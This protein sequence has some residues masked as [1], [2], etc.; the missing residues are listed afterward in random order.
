MGHEGGQLRTWGGRL[1]PF[2]AGGH[3]RFAR[4]AVVQGAAA[5]LFRTWTATVRAGLPALQGQVVI[6]L[7]D[8]LLLHV[9]QDRATAAAA[10]L[11]DALAEAAGRWA[12][13]SGVRFPADIAT[14][15]R[16]SDAKR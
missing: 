8:E 13:G 2:G 7:H 15:Q 5:E 11:T 16:W 4:N 6:C 3:G 10:L 1:L 9:P 14:V 12:T